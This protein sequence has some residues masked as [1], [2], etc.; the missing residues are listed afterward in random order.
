MIRATLLLLLT[1]FSLQL[2]SAPDLIISNCD[3]GSDFDKGVID[4]VLK[5]EGAGSLR[6]EHATIDRITLQDVPLD[7]SQHKSLSF[8]MHSN[9]AND[10]QF[11]LILTSENTTSEGLDYYSW[12]LKT[13]FTGWKQFTLDLKKFKG[14]RSPLGRDAIDGMMFTADG[15]GNTPNPDNILHIDAIT[16]T[17]DIPSPINLLENLQSNHPYLYVPPGGWAQVKENMLKQTHT[18]NIFTHI[19]AE[20]QALLT[21]P[22]S[23]YIL[24]DGK[25]LLAT[26]RAVLD[27]VITLAFSYQMTQNSAYLDR[28]VLEL[29]AAAAFPDWNPSHFLDVA[30]MSYAFALGYDW[31][32]ES[33]TPA[34]KILIENAIIEYA[35]TPYTEALSMSA[36][37]LQSEYN[38]N[39]VCNG[40]IGIGALAIAHIDGALANTVLNE[41]LWSL[42]YSG[43]VAQFGPDG[44]WEEGIGY[45]AYAVNYL[46]GFSAALESALGSSFSM[47]EYTGI[48]ETGTYPLYM[49]SPALKTFNYSDGGDG[50]MS[51]PWFYYM[52]EKYSNPMYAWFESLAH[53]NHP[54][55]ILMYT[56]N[57]Q[58]PTEL[59]LPLDRYYR[60]SEV[61]T[62]RSSWEGT[63]GIFAA[64]KAGN[65]DVGHSHLDIGE[66]IFDALGERWI[67]DYGSDDYSLP[68]YFDRNDHFEA[69]RWTYY[70]L[71]AEGNNTLVINPSLTADQ[72]PYAETVITT[73]Q[74]NNASMGFA[75]ANL[76][77][78][79]DD[80]G[81]GSVVRGV[82]LINER[83]QVLLQ[84][85]I[86]AQNSLDVW[87]FLNV[88]KNAAIVLSPDKKTATL[89][90]DDKRVV[91]SI[92]NTSEGT[93]SEMISAPLPS[94]PNPLN[95]RDNSQ[96]LAIHI[97]STTDLT[98]PILFTPLIASESMADKKIP[99]II[100][101]ESTQWP[102]AESTQYSSFSSPLSSS[103]ALSLSSS[104]QHVFSSQLFS[105]PSQQSS[106]SNILLSSIAIST[107]LNTF[108]VL[109]TICNQ[110]ECVITRYT[111]HGKVI[112]SYS[113]TIGEPFVQPSEHSNTPIIYSFVE[114]SRIVYGIQMMQ[115]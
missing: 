90:I 78:A 43:S 98:L 59:N 14:T 42:D 31:L 96:K 100:S 36:W 107:A 61:V 77:D 5:Q 24:P 75:K 57:V 68:G 115:Q 79:Y 106:S 38:W 58:T 92:L 6:W 93:F 17:G 81:A 35:L 10:Q 103:S 18:Q 46:F 65:N 23:E 88:N 34:Q 111:V 44:A 56:P 94:S 32:F 50:V 26:S 101:L 73:F 69:E 47:L 66:F 27:R 82:A 114:D 60:G 85:H 8:W 80:F 102:T 11:V 104:V 105:S 13:D 84:D 12:T 62:L 54:F 29:E 40:G 63:D 25:Q 20:A 48:S 53:S 95:Q 39:I 9:I 112:D 113:I 108:K 22:V 64:L 110:N 70:R 87:W 3:I 83:S 2:F 45:W 37:W 52:A 91:I 4:I 97:A 30:E 7:F 76:T 51:T 74:T 71:R 28:A 19:E 67:Y 89:T 1:V 16:L 99:E 41:V 72:D 49:T 55:D 33:L 21:E 86:T 109:P 15:W